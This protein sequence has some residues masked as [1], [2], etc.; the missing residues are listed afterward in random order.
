MEALL[1][2]QKTGALSLW[3]GC[4][5]IPKDEGELYANITDFTHQLITSSP[6]HGQQ[7]FCYK[8]SPVFPSAGYN[9]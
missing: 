7:Q 9:C 5:H 2:H 3:S 4:F 8:L 1:L 6:E